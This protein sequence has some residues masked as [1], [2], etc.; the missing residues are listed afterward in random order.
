MLITMGLSAATILLLFLLSNRPVAYSQ[1]FTRKIPNTKLIPI[2]VRSLPS[3]SY[4]IAGIADK[5]VYLA[6]MLDPL[7]LLKIPFNAGETELVRIDQE[8]MVL[9]SLSSIQIDSPYFFI[10]DGRSGQIG[11]GELNKW[12]VSRQLA[13][14]PA[15]EQA[16]SI[17]GSSAI[18][19]SLVGNESQLTN[20]LINTSKN[21]SHQPASIPIESKGSSFY[22][23]DGILRSDMNSNLLVYAYFYC[24]TYVVMDTSLNLIY[25]GNTIDTITTPAIKIARAS[26]GSY[27]L[28]STPSRVNNNSFVCDA[29]LFV[30]SAVMSTAEDRSSF[31]GASVID[32]YDLA[33]KK[34]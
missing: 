11:S 22:H 8:G 2:D 10:K 32:V 34:Y 4:Y 6:N 9:T 24:N 13:N 5:Y 23:S 30:H 7:S 3:D 31:E 20:V 25:K 26:N 21:Q 12:K 1:G 14:L 18:I 33:N 17:S 15:F 29:K 27:T 28:A 16:A 19:H